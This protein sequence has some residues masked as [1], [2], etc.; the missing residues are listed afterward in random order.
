MVLAKELKRYS[1]FDEKVVFWD[2]MRN[3]NQSNLFSLFFRVC[4]EEQ[5]ISS[6]TMI[7]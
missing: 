7:M 1:I 2:E 6:R 4:I 5:F 3:G